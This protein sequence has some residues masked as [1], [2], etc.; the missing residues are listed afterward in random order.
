MANIEDLST[1]EILAVALARYQ[2]QKK[3]LTLASQAK[4]L[5]PLAEVGAVVAHARKNQGMDSRSDLADLAD[6]ALSVVNSIE[7]S[8]GDLKVQTNKLLKVLDAL[9][10][11]VWIG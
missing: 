9:G 3:E 4:N 6:V 11:K 10:L 7:N 2:Q 1:E 8:D 5:K